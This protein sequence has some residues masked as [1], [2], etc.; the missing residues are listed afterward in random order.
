MKASPGP[1]KAACKLAVS[2]HQHLN[3]YALVTLW[4]GVSMM[5]LTV[6]AEAKVVYT[7]V[8]VSILGSGTF[9]LD[10]NHDQKA[11]FT[12][13]PY[14]R[15][16][17]C[18]PFGGGPFGSV[19]NLTVTPLQGNGVVASGNYAQALGSGV[20]INS[21]RSFYDAQ[22]L[23]AAFATCGV[24]GGGYETG[25]WYEVKNRYLGLRFEIDGETHY[26]WAK[27]SVQLVAGEFM[28][29]PRRRVPTLQTTLTG[30]AYETIPGQS[31]KTGQTS[32]SADDPTVPGSANPEDSDQH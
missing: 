2:I 30:F 7:A 1:C 24:G 28:G 25:E 22:A 8:D 17:Y 26:G 18:P 20:E 6:P 4:A 11:D 19:G 9:T 14:G 31:I 16:I 15:D 21:S 29:N 3:R 12:I 13:S 23:M 10:L 5:A 27:L 32:G